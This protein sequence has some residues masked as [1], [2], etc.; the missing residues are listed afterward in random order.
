MSANNVVSLPAKS[1]L[2]L[3]HNTTPGQMRAMVRDLVLWMYDNGVEHMHIARETGTAKI[4]LTVD[5]APL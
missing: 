2:E 3:K 5:G 1:R 4:M